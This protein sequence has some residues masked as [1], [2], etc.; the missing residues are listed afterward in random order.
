MTLKKISFVYITL[1]VLSISSVANQVILEIDRKYMNKDWSF[2]PDV[3]LTFNK[4][5]SKELKVGLNYKKLKLNISENNIALNLKRFSE[6]KNVSLNAK[7]SAASLGY[8][9]NDDDYLYLINSNQESD[10]QTFNCYEFSSITLG[11]CDSADLQI[12]SSNP[13]YESL[14]DNVIKISGL[15]ESIGLGYFKN[16]NTFWLESISFE[17]IN[18][19]YEYNWISPLEDIQSPLILNLD[20]NGIKL[21]DALEIAFNRLPQREEWES[22]QLNLSIKQKFYSIYNFNIIAEYDLIFLDFSDYAEYKMTQDTNLRIR[23]GIEFYF[24]N[25][26]ILFYGDAYLNNLIGFEPITFNQRTEHYF[27]EPYGELGIKFKISL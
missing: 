4:N 24:E 23:G 5:Q 17:L 19:S 13:K 3:P 7:K 9:L 6:P 1:L 22:L 21:G 16:L 11:F 12:T 14:G 27:D 2:L 18:T 20:F 26:S 15:T 25:L 8:L 10:N